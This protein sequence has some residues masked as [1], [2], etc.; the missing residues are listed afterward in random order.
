MG[1]FDTEMT[2]ERKQEL[3]A[4]ISSGNAIV[5]M[6]KCWW[7]MFDSHFD[8]PKWHTWADDEDIEHARD[9][10]QPDPRASRCGC[11]C[12]NV[13]PPSSS[14]DEGNTPDE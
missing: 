8:P 4:A 1:E 3:A 7:C 12:A 2:P 11:Y 10:G 14:V 9:T 13:S 6:T 5:C